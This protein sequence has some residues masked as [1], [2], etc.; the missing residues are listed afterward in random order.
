VKSFS[1][2]FVRH[3]T[4]I[5]RTVCPGGIEREIVAD[6]IA[7]V[8]EVSVE[9]L[10]AGSSARWFIARIDRAVGLNAERDFI[11]DTVLVDIA[12]VVVHPG[13]RG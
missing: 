4:E 6:R 1:A 7:F 5:E 9:P 11:G 8:V 12:H 3:G 10:R 13:T 2:L